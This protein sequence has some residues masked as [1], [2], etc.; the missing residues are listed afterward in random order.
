MPYTKSL[1]TIKEAAAILRLSPKT[2]YKRGA[3]TE[4]LTMM[5]QGRLVRMIR[6]EVEAH[7]DNL[8]RIAQRRAS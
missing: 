1:I 8:I 7:V 3:G 5:R 4:R 6:Q 2:L